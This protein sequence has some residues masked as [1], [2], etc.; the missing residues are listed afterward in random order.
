MTTVCDSVSEIPSGG[1]QC[2][3]GHV[4]CG[5]DNGDDDSI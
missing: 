2:V 1:G 4:C 3:D 5:G